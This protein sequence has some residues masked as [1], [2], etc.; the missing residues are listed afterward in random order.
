MDTNNTE[1]PEEE[2]PPAIIC[3]YCGTVFSSEEDLNS[4]L[5]SYRSK[6]ENDASEEGDDA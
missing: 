6:E 5:D 4:H 3:G 1:R 2:N